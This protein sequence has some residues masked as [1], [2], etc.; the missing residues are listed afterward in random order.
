MN[1]PIYER[2]EKRLEKLD[3]KVDLIMSNCLPTLQGK[4]ENLAGS[5]SVICKL[6]IGIAIGTAIA[7]VGILIKFILG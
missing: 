6:V 1:E 2:I 4:V 3:E 7:L 5:Y